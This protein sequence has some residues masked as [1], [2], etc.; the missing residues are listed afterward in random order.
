MDIRATK[1]ALYLLDSETK[2]FELAT[3]FGFRSAVRQSANANDPMVE[4]CSR[5]R[6][7]FYV[8]NPATD[9]RLSELLFE[10]STERMLGV[11]LFSRGQLVGFI[12]MRDKAQNQPFDQPDLA[13]AQ[14]IADRILALFSTKNIWN[15]RFITM[16]DSEMVRLPQIS[17]TPAESEAPSPR[18]G[19]SLAE[20]LTAS[21]TIAVRLRDPRPPDP[22]GSSELAAITDTLRTMLLMPGAIAVAF[23]ATGSAG[24]IQE[25]ASR[26][27]MTEGALSAL[28]MK[29]QTW[30]DKR[31]ES[32][33]L[34][35]TTVRTPLG[36]TMPPIAAAQLEKVF[37]AAVSV[38]NFRGLYVTVAFSG[39]PERNT[40]E[41]LGAML[42]QLQAS[43]ESSALRTTLQD[44][45]MRI[46]E[47]L[48]EPEHENFPDL[49]RHCMSVLDL[50][51]TFARQLG[52]GAAESEIAQLTALV[53]D[54]GMRLLD[55]DRLYRKRDLNH[56]EL[57]LLK[58]HVTV[59][60]SIVEPL[61]GPDIAR[62]VLSHHE[63]VDGAGYPNQ[64]RGEEIPL[65]SRVLQICD[66]YITITDPATYQM[67]E[68]PDE[69]L[70]AIRR[71]GGAQFDRELAIRFEEM[72][73]AGV[74][75]TKLATR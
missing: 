37:S 62:A 42:I 38:P 13:K 70:A 15:Q 14:G 43:I 44:T 48:V 34:L 20:M 57:E 36:V 41:L 11:P 66:A 75:S 71:G 25:I 47:R 22:I 63:R 55:Y 73:R 60:A 2:K 30:L 31:G 52:L 28:Q 19:V 74:Q 8:N 59:G 9:P 68:T 33:G 12:D 16:S 26:G 10:A 49:R 61:L 54:C 3:E 23:S 51:S 27:T 65:A 6:S 7:P 24:E 53:H 29:L 17:A 21:R 69:A 4:R 39:M 67:P 1:A 35:R 58:E 40:H 50:T 32:A 18:P 56:D 45:R 64:L 46:A 5:G 72:M